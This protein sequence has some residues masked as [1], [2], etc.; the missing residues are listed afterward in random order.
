[1]TFDPVRYILDRAAD[2]VISSANCE[3]LPW[4]QI[5]AIGPKE[6]ERR[7]TTRIDPQR[8]EKEWG[9]HHAVTGEF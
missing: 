1:M 7:E 6:A 2:D 8:S 3:C 4:S 9:A 5:L